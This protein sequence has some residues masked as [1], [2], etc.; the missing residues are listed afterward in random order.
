M[1]SDDLTDRINRIFAA[2]GA[3]QETDI[4]KFKPKVIKDGHRVGFY[5]DW[6]AELNDA[7]VANFA[8]SLINNI[9]SLEYHLKKWAD[10]NGQDKTIVEKAFA[11][12]QELKIIHDLWNNE[13]H[14]YPPRKPSKSGLC[15]RVDKF[16]RILQMT[17]K[18]E[19]GSSMRLTFNMQG[20]PQTYYLVEGQYPPANSFRF[21]HIGGQS[22]AYCFPAPSLAVRYGLLF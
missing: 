21:N 15:P 2:V 11:N 17:T 6:M 7:D 10:R 8:I 5:Q 16:N 13:K 4:S 22:P 14:G 3:V 9:A 1:V 19:K 20:I 18:P 12:T